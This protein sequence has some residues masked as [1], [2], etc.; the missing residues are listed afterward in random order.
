LGE[1]EKG[2]WRGKKIGF[3]TPLQAGHS[4]DLKVLEVGLGAK[5]VKEVSVKILE[6]RKKGRHH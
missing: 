4:K 1:R 5:R 6:G 2:I 3:H